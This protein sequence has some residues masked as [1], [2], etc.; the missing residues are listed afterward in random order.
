MLKDQ[1]NKQAHEDSA[2]LAC[3]AAGSIHTV[4]A[5]TREDGCLRLYSEGLEEPLQRSNR[6][7][8]WS[9]ALFS[10]TQSLVFFVIALIFGYGAVLVSK[11]QANTFQFFV[12]LMVC[13]Y[14]SR[15]LT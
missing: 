6:T 7:A 4:A 10:F 2:H 9:S 5:L 15:V 3:E 1:T 14:W 8:I 11:Q 13:I 12:G